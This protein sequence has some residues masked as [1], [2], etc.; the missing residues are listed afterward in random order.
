MRAIQAINCLSGRPPDKVVCLFLCSLNL[1]FFFPPTFLSSFV[2]IMFF[3]P[4]LSS[5]FRIFLCRVFSFF[6]QIP[7]ILLYLLL[8]CSLSL[9]LKILVHFLHDVDLFPYIGL[10]SLGI[11]GRELLGRLVSD[12][13]IFFRTNLT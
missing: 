12:G 7:Y 4:V 11:G 10:E 6:S 9:S 1:F 8:L 2:F 13:P 3:T 5:F